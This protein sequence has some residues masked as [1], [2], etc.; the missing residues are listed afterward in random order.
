MLLRRAMSSSPLP[1]YAN[2]TLNHLAIAIEVLTPLSLAEAAW[3]NVGLMVEAPKPRAVTS[4]PKRVVCCIDCKLLHSP[5][6]QRL[7]TDSAHPQEVT[8]A[9]VKEALAHPSTAA[10]VTYHPPIFSGLK[11]LRLGGSALQASLLNCI[12]EGVPEIGRAS[13]R[14]RVS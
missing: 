14:E 9:V 12:T 7:L 2:P 11:S 4:G 5:S 3:D 1:R 10:I 13:C 8:T 6:F